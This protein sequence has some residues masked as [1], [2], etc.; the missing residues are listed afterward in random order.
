MVPTSSRVSG[1]LEYKAQALFIQQNTYLNPRVSGSRRARKPPT[2]EGKAGYEK[3]MVP[4][5]PPMMRAGVAGVVTLG[6]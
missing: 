1:S 3:W 2:T 5:V 4:A 6:R